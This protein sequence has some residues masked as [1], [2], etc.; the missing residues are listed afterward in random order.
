MYIVLYD[1]AYADQA[2]AIIDAYNNASI[3][4]SN[5]DAVKVVSFAGQDL[6]NERMVQSLFGW[7]NM[8][9]G[10]PTQMGGMR[11][12]TSGSPISATETTAL[13]GNAVVV[14]EDMRDL[15]Y[16]VNADVSKKQAWYLHTDPLINVPLTKRATGSAPV[17]VWLTPEQRQGDWSEYTYKIVKRSMLVLEPNLRAKRIM[18]FYT[19]VIP[20][21]MTSAQVAMQMGIAFNVP[22]ALMQAAEEM[23]ISD[24]L[25][26]IFE[27]PTFRK[28][29]DYFAMQGPKDA[30]KGGL[31]PQGVGQQGGYP[32]Q[33]SILTPGQEFNQEAQ[34]LAGIGQS[35]MREF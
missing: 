14:L 5:P 4:C 18:E 33:H 7:F 21:V 32:L 29:M 20:A 30:G 34:G 24:A 12:P 27:D 28:H 9:A 31:S 8:I 2:Q 35:A 10:N 1:P 13:Q 3:A 16:D 26:E 11:S 15:T 25:N 6:E 22:R 17:Q 23:G 19:N